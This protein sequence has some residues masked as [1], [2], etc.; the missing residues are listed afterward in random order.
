MTLNRQ[1][2]PKLI[3]TPTKN[4][5]RQK[6]EKLKKL[7]LNAIIRPKEGLNSRDRREILVNQIY[8]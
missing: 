2:S 7:R 8:N 4:T 5:N 1:I 3:P 6:R